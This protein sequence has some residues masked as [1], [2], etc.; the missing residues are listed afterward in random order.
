MVEPVSSYPTMTTVPLQSTA[1][2]V[3]LLDRLV[4]CLVEPPVPLNPYADVNVSNLVMQAINDGPVDN[5]GFQYQPVILE[6]IP[7]LEL[8]EV[9]LQPVVVRKGDHFFN[10]LDGRVHIYAGAETTMDQM[11]VRFSLKE[12]I[13]WSDGT[14]LTAHDSQYA[15]DLLSELP[16]ELVEGWQPATELL[17][18]KTASYQALDN[19]TTEWVG[20]PGLVSTDFPKFF[21]SPMPRHLGT[22]LHTNYPKVGWGGFQIK[23]WIPGSH[24]I[25]G[26]NSYYFR[27]DENLPNVEEVEFRFLGPTFDNIPGMIS[28]TGCHIISLSVGSM[29]A[30]EEWIDS[31]EALDFRLITVPREIGLQLAFNL[32]KDASAVSDANVRRAI[33][34]CL[35]RADLAESVHGVVADSYVHPLDTVHMSLGD[36]SFAPE[37]GSQLLEE[38]GWKAQELTLTLALSDSPMKRKIGDKIVANLAE[39]GITVQVDY[40]AYETFYLPWP[41]GPI[42]GGS[43][44]MVVFPLS[45]KDGPACNTYL[46][47]NIPSASYPENFNI[48]GFQ[49][50]EFDRLCKDALVELDTEERARLHQEAQA[51]WADHLPAIPLLWLAHFTGVDC[52]VDGYRI[53]PIGAELWNIEDIRLLSECTS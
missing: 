47:D 51:L 1:T 19:Y 3:P 13:S 41:E 20:I 11:V 22:D 5:V 7:S 6:S 53:D 42:Y 32:G 24:L 48:T 31:A 37:L 16:I 39:C 2:D 45:A 35:D 33:G 18:L 28:E 43:Y 49:N 40:L 4:I 25:L 17:L 52:H 15:Y 50:P 38:A 23:V 30:A 27:A 29:L 8:G 34:Y 46:S 14:P 44:N 9:I 21:F 10:P 26:R 36:Y 12:G